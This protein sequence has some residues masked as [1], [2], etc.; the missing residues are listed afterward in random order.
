MPDKPDQKVDQIYDVK[1]IE[2]YF[3]GY[4]RDFIQKIVEHVQEYF[5]RPR[6]KDIYQHHN[7]WFSHVNKILDYI[8]QFCK[9]SGL[10]LN[11]HETNI[12]II[13][14]ILHDIGKSLYDKHPK[15][16]PGEKRKDG[17]LDK[18]EN[19]HHIL[20]FLHIQKIIKDDIF[21]KDPI[22]NTYLH[23]AAWIALRHKKIDDLLFHLFKDDLKP[24]YKMKGKDGKTESENN[25]EY[26]KSGIN[27]FEKETGKNPD[28]KDINNFLIQNQTKFHFEREELD[29]F[30][31]LSALLQLGDNLDITKNRIKPAKF[32][33]EVFLDDLFDRDVDRSHLLTPFV[34]T[35]WY[36][37]YY[38]E[39]TL[40][41]KY[42]DKQPKRSHDTDKKN[43]N[44]NIKITIC[45]K[46]PE[47]MRDDF[48]FFRYKAEKDFDDLAIISIL[49]KALR[50]HHDDEDIRI[51]LTRIENKEEKKEDEKEN[52][53]EKDEEKG[54]DEAKIKSQYVPGRIKGLSDRKER[55]IYCLNKICSNVSSLC[56]LN[57]KLGEISG[58]PL[59]E[60]H[61]YHIKKPAIIES[62]ELIDRIQEAL[63]NPPSIASHPD[64]RE[65]SFGLKIN[66]SRLLCPKAKNIPSSIVEY[67]EKLLK[68][69][70]M[71]G[72]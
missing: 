55:M 62:C 47:N 38:T 30:S 45:Y 56:L 8:G 64:W 24:F 6:Y 41:E 1:I 50:I 54:Q 12:I 4:D 29:A 70:V 40:I 65:Y 22:W 2:D 48:L 3:K 63:K 13:A 35:K 7:D 16:E 39:K 5:S 71:I 10:N 14:T 21:K 20:S 37:F 51:T 9:E 67:R 58:K 68:D 42:P 27:Y 32:F 46:Y 33:V 17:D 66:N 25:D 23:C 49:E 69:D 11:P 19:A 72:L 59:N 26:M 60:I 18:L 52:G 31:V 36:Q 53:K 28:I 44:Y 57:D 34:I 61:E 43:E 15:L